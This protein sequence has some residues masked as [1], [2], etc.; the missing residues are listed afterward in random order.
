VNVATGI[1]NCFPEF[2]KY[3]SI[4][5][6]DFPTQN[7]KKYFREALLFMRDA[8]EGNGKVISCLEIISFTNIYI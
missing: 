3:L 7:L 2:F 4:N 5:A 8:V 1:K 6:V